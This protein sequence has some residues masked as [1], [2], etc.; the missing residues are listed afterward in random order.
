M[1]RL[2]IHYYINFVTVLL[3]RQEEN[4]GKNFTLPLVGLRVHTDRSAT[5][6]AY[7]SSGQVYTSGC[8]KRLS[9]SPI[10]AILVL[11]VLVP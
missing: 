10:Y 2:L 9:V 1:L 6:P 5:P 7:M 11:H 3:S 4:A 8:E